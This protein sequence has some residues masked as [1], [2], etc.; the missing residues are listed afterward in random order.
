VKVTVSHTHSLGTCERSR[1]SAA[2]AVGHVEVTAGQSGRTVEV[3][4]AADNQ[5][6]LGERRAAGM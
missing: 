5:G 3:R 1:G 6:V 2:E 4:A